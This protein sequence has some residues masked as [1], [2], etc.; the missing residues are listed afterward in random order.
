MVG[1][2]YLNEFFNPRLRSNFKK[3]IEKFLDVKG[4]VD[5]GATVVLRC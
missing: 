4:I 1:I 5:F 3:G 2:L